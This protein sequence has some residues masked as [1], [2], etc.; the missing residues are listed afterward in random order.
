M[1]Q[2]DL[3][4]IIGLGRTGLSCAYYCAERDIPFAVTDTRLSPP[5]LEEFKK[6]FPHVTLSLGALD[7]GLLDK[8][9]S[10]I[11]SPGI[12]L[13]ES[14]IARQISQGVPIVGDIELFSL[15]TKMPVIAIT[16]TNAKSTV[17]TLVGEMALEAGFKAEVGGNLGTP[18]LDLLSKPE[19][20]LFVLELSSFQLEA[21]R[22]LKPNVATVLNVTPDHF[23]KYSPPMFKVIK[24]IQAG[25]SRR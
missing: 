2:A 10:L 25:T 6:A 13:K 15:E 7:E 5:H 19:A 22:S 24:H 4:V 8:A 20:D 21:T 16:G 23:T 1:R 3:H 12:S 9:S 17:T 14:A 11:V 18:V